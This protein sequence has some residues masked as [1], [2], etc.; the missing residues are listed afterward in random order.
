[1]ADWL[2]DVPVAHRGLHGDDI[3]ENTMEAFINAVENG[4]NIELDVQ[5]TKDKQMVVF[6]DDSLKRM[7]GIDKNLYEFTYD[8]LLRMKFFGSD[9]AY[10]PLFSDVCE[11]CEGKV[12]IMI[13][14]KKNPENELDHEVEDVLLEIL[15]DYPN[16]DCIL[17]SFNPF[18]VNYVGEKAPQYRRGFLSHKDNLS[19]YTDYQRPMVERL[20]FSEDGRVDFFDYH[21]RQMG[22]PL[23]EQVL[24]TMP[25]FVW[26]VGSEEVANRIKDEVDNYI[27][28]GFKAQKA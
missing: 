16:L 18:A 13:E 21:Y 4:Y 9:T 7:I 23:Y 22:S 10:I 15:E 8:E 3:V 24:G 2:Y 5:L 27:F 20:L 25:I 19:D 26:T 1:M 28:E 11:I 17:K 14:I 12:G 6:H